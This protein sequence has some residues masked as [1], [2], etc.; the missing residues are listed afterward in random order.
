MW[1]T[2][3]APVWTIAAALLAQFLL[4]PFFQFIVFR[5]HWFTPVSHATSGLINSTLLANAIALVIIVAGVILLGGRLRPKDVGLA[6]R[7]LV[8]GI[9]FTLALWLTVNAVLI[10]VELPQSTPF[11]FNDMWRKPGAQHVIGDLIAQIFGTALDEE[12]VFRGFLTVQV[13]LLLRPLG[14]SAAFILAIVVVQLLFASVHVPLL[15]EEGQH[16]AEIW[17]GLPLLF[18][19]GT[20]FALLYF[21]TGNLFVAVGTHAL[22]NAVVLIPSDP[23]QS[24]HA[25]D[26][27]YLG[28]AIVAAI[29]WRTTAQLRHKN[30]PQP[31]PKTS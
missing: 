2:K 20:G 28:L 19:F 27:L 8:A 6:G 23:L 15:L 13:M 12:I 4:A 25:L 14:K 18:A 1:E 17:S 26:F 22:I 3:R 30:R 31:Q 24:S 7:S 9:G 11:A 5:R 10:I 16:G 21:I 29:A